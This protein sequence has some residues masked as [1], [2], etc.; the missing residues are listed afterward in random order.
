MMQTTLTQLR[1]LKLEGLATALEEQM[2]QAGMA[3]LS[4]EERSP[5]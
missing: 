5:C 2:A 3:A 4:F 1:E